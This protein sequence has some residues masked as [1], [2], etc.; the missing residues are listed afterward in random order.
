M[1]P[2]SHSN[3]VNFD[4]FDLLLNINCDRLTGKKYDTRDSVELVD[5][6]CRQ[7]QS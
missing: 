3:K 4:L 7:I 1:Q 2:I 5:R 6:T